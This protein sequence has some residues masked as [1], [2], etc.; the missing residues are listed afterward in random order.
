MILRAE[1]R[2]GTSAINLSGLTQTKKREYTHSLHDWYQQSQWAK[3]TKKK[4]VWRST[5][6][7]IR[8]SKYS[9]IL[10]KMKG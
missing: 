9:A 10:S 8:H 6:L 3:I 5:I 4:T 1:G 2:C 7:L